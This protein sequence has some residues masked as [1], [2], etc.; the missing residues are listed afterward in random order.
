MKSG[1]PVKHDVSVTSMA[2]YGI[3]SGALYSNQY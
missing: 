1:M 3:F 2:V